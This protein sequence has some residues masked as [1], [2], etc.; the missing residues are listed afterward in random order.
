LRRHFN[1]LLC[2]V[3]L[4]VFMVDKVV[5]LLPLETISVFEIDIAI[6]IDNLQY[7]NF[8]NC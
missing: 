4:K 6:T 7:L 2:L 3:T 8:S 1:F 5:L